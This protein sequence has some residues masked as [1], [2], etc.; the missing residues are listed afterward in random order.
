MKLLLPAFALAAAPNAKKA[1]AEAGL[2]AGSFAV[3]VSASVFE[4]PGSGP[5]AAL[6]CGYAALAHIHS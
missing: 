3:G 1:P 6:P 2:A 5:P 4:G